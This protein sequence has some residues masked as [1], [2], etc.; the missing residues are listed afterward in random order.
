VSLAIGIDLGTTNVK[1][2][3]VDEDG[4]L[5]ASAARSIE[6]VREGDVVEQDA[7]AVWTQ[8][9][10]AVA[11]AVGAVPGAADDVVALG[12]CSQY[13]S[14]IPVDAEAR[15]VAPMAT[16]QDKRGTDHSWEVLAQEEAFGLWLERHGIPPV[17][18]GLSLAH[19]LHFQIDRPDV[20]EHT[21][22]YL[23]PMD[24]VAAV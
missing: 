21:A 8:V 9:L 17:G 6:M 2:A 12:V 20:H 18:N 7:E 11:E 5:V 13:S 1:A 15:P 23:E 22:A 10:D 4:R 3:L 16:W 14:I 19:I 24:Y